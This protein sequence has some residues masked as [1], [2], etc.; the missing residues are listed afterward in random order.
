M[1]LELLYIYKDYCICNHKKSTLE[2][3]KAFL[4]SYNIK[5]DIKIYND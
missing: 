1:D 2:G 3:F 5:H 4:D